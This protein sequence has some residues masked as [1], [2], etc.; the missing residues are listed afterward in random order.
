MFVP[1]TWNLS[2]IGIPRQYSDLAKGSCFCHDFSQPI[3][4]YLLISD[5]GVTWEIHASQALLLLLECG[6]NS[7]E[8]VDGETV[9]DKLIWAMY[10]A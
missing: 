8:A 7:L 10:N 5:V 2:N 6:L 3:S 1:A 9:L 4:L